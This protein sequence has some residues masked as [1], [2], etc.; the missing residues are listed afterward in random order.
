MITRRLTKTTSAYVTNE[1]KSYIG[2][3]GPEIISDPIDR[4]EIRRFIQAIMDQDPIHWDDEHVKNTRYGSIVAPPLF[5]THWF[6]TPP[7]I[8]D[9]LSE[10]FKKDPQFDGL[11]REKNGPELPDIPLK[12]ALNGGNEIEF[13]RYPEVGERISAKGKIVDIFEKEG[14]SGRLVFI[15]TETTFKG[16]ENNKIILIA[17]Q[18][19][20][21]R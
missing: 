6:R 13:F 16:Y 17:R 4:S 8:P 11:L 20:I 2:N 19:L 18:T 14:R 10:N 1:V 15:V 12:R 9:P 5:V 7:G 21:K 3:E